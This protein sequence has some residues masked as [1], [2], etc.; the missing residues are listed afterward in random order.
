[1]AAGLSSLDFQGI[2]TETSAKNPPTGK[3][4]IM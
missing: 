1:M 2:Y 4:E 3:G